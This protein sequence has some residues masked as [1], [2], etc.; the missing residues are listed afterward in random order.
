MLILKW[1]ETKTLNLYLIP[2]YKAVS[3]N[4]DPQEES[5]G[6]MQIYRSSFNFH[7]ELWSQKSKH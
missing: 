5:K 1:M 3:G 4:N 6:D 2:E 7:V